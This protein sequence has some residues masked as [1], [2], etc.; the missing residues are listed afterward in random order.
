MGNCKICRYW[1]R[2]DH[3]CTAVESWA[4]MD[5]RVKEDNFAVAVS[6]SDDRG[7]DILFKTGPDFGCIKF[8]E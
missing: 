8:Q 7:L 3:E 1:Y 5:T 2:P 6:Y 4:N